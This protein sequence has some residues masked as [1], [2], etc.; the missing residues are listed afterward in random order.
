MKDFNEKLIEMCESDVSSDIIKETVSGSKLINIAYK[1]YEVLH[2]LVKRRD[3]EIIRSLPKNWFWNN[4]HLTKI[5]CMISDTDFASEVLETVLISHEEM[6]T[7][8]ERIYPIIKDLI[9]N[10][11]LIDVIRRHYSKEHHVICYALTCALEGNDSETVDV[12]INDFV[13]F[14]HRDQK[15]FA[16]GFVVRASNIEDVEQFKKVFLVMKPLCKWKFSFADSKYERFSVGSGFLE[17]RWYA[18]SKILCGCVSRESSVMTEFF[19]EN[20]KEIDVW[21]G[22]TLN[23]FELACKE[24]RLGSIKCLLPYVLPYRV[25]AILK[26]CR[27]EDVIETILSSEAFR[28]DSVALNLLK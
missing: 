11:K 14:E 24:K 21:S 8:M 25:T 16:R 23:S 3:I 17:R 9:K 6:F 20:M 26:E 15:L 1:D 5:L 22:V 18:L 7:P 10:R 12:L 19:L 27:D 4:D 13:M 28:F 2:A